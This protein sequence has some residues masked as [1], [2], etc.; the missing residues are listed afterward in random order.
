[1]FLDRQPASLPA[2]IGRPTSHVKKFQQLW[3][4]QIVDGG[5]T[6]GPTTL[7]PSPGP[8]TPTGSPWGSD[9]PDQANLTASLILGVYI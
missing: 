5:R 9:L 6:E 3:V 2:A 4:G 1:M 8:S 7:G